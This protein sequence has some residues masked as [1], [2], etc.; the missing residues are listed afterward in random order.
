MQ[1]ICH[2]M[3]EPSSLPSALLLNALQLH[4]DMQSVRLG[5]PSSAP[6]SHHLRLMLASPSAPS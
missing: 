4:S 5:A 3:D 6:T 2:G 1:V